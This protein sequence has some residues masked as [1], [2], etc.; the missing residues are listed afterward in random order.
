MEYLYI[1]SLLIVF[2]TTWFV[3][4]F[5]IIRLF[6]YYKEAEEKEEPSKSILQKQYT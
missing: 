2:V 3:R 4:L 5:Y 1:K 6:I